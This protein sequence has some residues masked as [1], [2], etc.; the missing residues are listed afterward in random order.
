MKSISTSASGKRPGKTT[1]RKRM[2]GAFAL[3]IFSSV[4]ANCNATKGA[5]KDMENLGENIQNSAEKSKP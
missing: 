5:G 2:L 1:S 4:L 3:V